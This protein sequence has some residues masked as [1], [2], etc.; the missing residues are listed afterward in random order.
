MRYGPAP[1]GHAIG[2]SHGGGDACGGKVKPLAA[3]AVPSPLT[4]KE[5]SVCEVR[6]G[7][8]VT[9]AGDAPAWRRRTVP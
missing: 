6:K 3:S 7:N 9:V 1:K 4:A 2:W 5:N 8:V